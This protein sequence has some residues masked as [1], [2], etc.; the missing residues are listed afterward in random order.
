[1]LPPEFVEKSPILTAGYP[2]N[3]VFFADIEGSDIS[4]DQSTLEVLNNPRFTKRLWYAPTFRRG[5]QTID[6]EAMLDL[7]RLTPWLEKKDYQIVVR[8]NPK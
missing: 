1:M 4:V 2:R 8:L 7:K 5:A 6:I 3:D